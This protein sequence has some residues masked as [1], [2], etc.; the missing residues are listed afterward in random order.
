MSLAGQRVCA[1]PPEAVPPV[2]GDRS[3]WMGIVATVLGLALM[4]GAFGNGLQEA[5]PG[6]F[7]GGT[8][9]E[10]IEGSEA[11]DRIA[12]LG[13]AD[14]IVGL[15]GDD[16]AAG[17]DGDDEL[18]GGT[19]RDVLLAGEGDDFAEARDG[20]RDYVVCGAGRDVVRADTSDRVAS[21]CETVYTT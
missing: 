12:G 21:D 7:S 1:P 18:Y 6:V 16:F 4:V 8:S 11:S 3:R 2:R 13:G 10:N 17:G 19:G 20:E 5:Q 15:D 14:T 9:G